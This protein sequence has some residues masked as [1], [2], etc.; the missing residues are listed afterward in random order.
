[1]SPCIDTPR[2]V[3]TARALARTAAALALLQPCLAHASLLSGEALDTMANVVAWI[4]LIIVPVV[5]IAVFWIVHILPERIAEKRRHPQLD[6]IKTLCL[7][8][9]VF[10]GLLWPLAWLWAYTRPV[11]H[12]LAYGTDTADHHGHGSDALTPLHDA[13][14]APEPD[15]AVE[16]VAQSA[17]DTHARAAETQAEVDEMRRRIRSLEMALAMGQRPG[18]RTARATPGDDEE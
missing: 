7:L 6:A 13:T 3:R 11:L 17:V 14:V 2:R 8:S 5:L 15:T 10:G 9:L 16:P 18:E 1:M 4:A 12:K